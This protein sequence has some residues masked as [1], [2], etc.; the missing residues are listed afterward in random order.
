MTAT[1]VK[2]E[3]KRLVENLPDTASWDDLMYE[4]YVRQ[5][6]EDGIKAADEDR[7]LTHEEVRKRFGTQ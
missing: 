1:S 7:V 5:K 2:N 3:A 6:I 4:V